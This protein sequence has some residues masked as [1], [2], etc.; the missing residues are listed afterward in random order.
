MWPAERYGQVAV[1]LAK[2]GLPSLINYG[3]GE[4]ELATAVEAAGAGAARRIS[5]SVSD[6]IALTRRAALFIGGDTGPMHMAAALKV[7]VVAIFGPTNP[8]RNGP[9]G[10]RSIVLRSASSVTDHTRRR[11]PE[12][13]LLAITAGEVV[14]AARKLLAKGISESQ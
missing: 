4:E 7:P 11:D 3:P 2:D 1:E 5:C 6:L 14:N 10:T 12:Q 8:Q 13:G 9:F